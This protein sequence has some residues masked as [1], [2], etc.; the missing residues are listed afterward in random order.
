MQDGSLEWRRCL[1]QEY[2]PKENKFLINWSFKN[3]LQKVSRLNI[4]LDDIEMVEMD[5][6]RIKATN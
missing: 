2:L 1:I 5:K 3:Q 4:A 6:R